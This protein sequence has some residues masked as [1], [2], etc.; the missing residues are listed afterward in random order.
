MND[1]DVNEVVATGEPL[2]PELKF[3][4]GLLQEEDLM[5]LP[6]FNVEKVVKAAGE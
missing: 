2:P 6:E 1:D 4:P 5:A 3:D